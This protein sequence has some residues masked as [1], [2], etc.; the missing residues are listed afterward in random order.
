MSTLTF[1]HV[2]SSSSHLYSQAITLRIYLCT[3]FRSKRKSI[4]C[5]VFWTLAAC[6]SWSN[7]NIYLF[8]KYFNNVNDP[9]CWGALHDYQEK[10]F[11]QS[12]HFKYSVLN[13]QLVNTFSPKSNFRKQITIVPNRVLFSSAYS[14]LISQSLVFENYSSSKLNILSTPIFRVINWCVCVLFVIKY[15]SICG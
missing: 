15:S 7:V 1:D 5:F 12:N 4:I 10:K 13:T 6:T 8:W 11:T 2:K 9:H 14:T 3:I